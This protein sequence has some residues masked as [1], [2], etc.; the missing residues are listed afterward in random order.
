MSPPVHAVA[1]PDGGT[2]LAGRVYG[3]GCGSPMSVVLS[4][5]A[6]W[7]C[8]PSPCG[9]HFVRADGLDRAVARDVLTASPEAFDPADPVASVTAA[10]AA[11]ISHVHVF[12]YGTEYIPHF[13]PVAAGS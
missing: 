11:N 1:L 7:Y 9:R 8:C 12:E 5:G 2:I 10:V 6:A 13:A 3:M 4:D